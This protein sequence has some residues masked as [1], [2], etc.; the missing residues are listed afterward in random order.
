MLRRQIQHQLPAGC[1]T[2]PTACTRSRVRVTV[3]T[4]LLQ[5]ILHIQIYHRHKGFAAA[6]TYAGGVRL[7]A[8]LIADTVFSHALGEGIAAV[9]RRP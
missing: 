4:Q 8:A 6:E 9:P 1:R 7:A 3:G 2:A 5:V